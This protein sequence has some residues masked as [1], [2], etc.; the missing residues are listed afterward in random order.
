M[1]ATPC[2]ALAVGMLA[3]AA[4]CTVAGQPARA[5]EAPRSPLQYRVQ[6]IDGKE[7][8]LSRYKGKVVLI[9]NVASKCGLTPQYASLQKLYDRFRDQG[10][11]I[12][13][14]PAN[15]FGKQEPGTNAEIKEF[16]TANYK[17]TFPMFSKIIVKGEGIHPLY[18]FLTDKKTNPKFAGE[19]E[20]NF[21]K[22][23]VGRSGQVVARIPANVDPLKPEVVTVI[24]RELAAAP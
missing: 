8:D 17:V 21:A 1:N 5:E 13:G 9:V 15:E 4:C 19:I 24:E 10:L 3:V 2:V 12:L 6:D 7:V 20:W 14:F 18:H 22:F 16:C 11:V 23:V